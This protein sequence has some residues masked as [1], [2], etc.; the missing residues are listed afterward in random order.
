MCVGSTADLVNQCLWSFVV[1]MPIWGIQAARRS[2]D[3]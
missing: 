1:G 2:G 3:G